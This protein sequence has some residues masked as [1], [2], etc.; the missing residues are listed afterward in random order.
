MGCEGGLNGE[1]ACSVMKQVRRG[2]KRP[3]QSVVFLRTLRLNFIIV[4]GISICLLLLSTQMRIAIQKS[5]QDLC[6]SNLE[7]GLTQLNAQLDTVSNDI[8]NFRE[9]IMQNSPGGLHRYD[10]VNLLKAQ[11]TL[12]SILRG[13]PLLGE[14]AYVCENIDQVVTT[15]G[16]FYSIDDFNAAYN[17]E[18][19]D[20]NL[21]YSYLGENERLATIRF[22]PCTYVDS[23]YA[24]P[25][26]DAA[27][28]CAIPLDTERY[29]T[30]KGVAYT[31]LRQDELVS[32]AVSSRI[33]P[34]ASF[35]LYDNRAGRGDVCLMSYGEEIED[36]FE[37]VLVSSTGTLRAVIRVS[38]AYINAQMRDVNR[39]IAFLMIAAVLVGVGTAY[40]TAHRQYIPMRRVIGSLRE[41]NLLISPDR[42]EY[43]E[44]LSS[45]DTLITEKEIV[46]RRLSDYQESL[47]RN[48]LDRLFSNTL[49]KQDVEVM[50]RLQMK[51]FPK[52]FA[53][54]CG[55][56]FVGSADSNDSM[57]MTLVMLLD[58]L[59]KNLPANAILHSTD[60]ATFGLVYP[61]ENGLDAAEEALQRTLNAASE[62]FS[63]HVLLIRG[64]VC[65]SM[66]QIGACF[67]K[68]QMSY[69]EDYGQYLTDGVSIVPVQ[70]RAESDGRW[71]LRRLQALY[72]MMAAGNADRA[73]EEMREIYLSSGDDMP[74]DMRERYTML[75]A[76]I[77]MACPEIQEDMACPEIPSFQ[78]AM[79]QREQLEA[80]ERAVREVC[81]HVVDW[82]TDAMDERVNVYADY[83]EA[84][85]DDPELC[86]SSLAN[87][88][89]VSEKY[90]FTLFKKKTGYSPT[91]YLHHIRMEK[92]AQLLRETDDTVQNISARVGFANFGTFYKAFKREFGVAPGKFRAG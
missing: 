56:L 35:K 9:L 52:R 89:H 46:T 68:A 51:D 13:N 15:Q 69:I 57:Q 32:V 71:R 40:W 29:T 87:E 72:Q 36:G 24:A 74:I 41:R 23:R 49:L 54:Y 73:V 58:Y 28:C 77:L 42:D 18:G 8:I 45:V 31:F 88:F 90:L 14:I 65:E 44:L 43:D 84:H 26:F 80:L 92:A 47:Q 79:P 21:F 83:M 55:R 22:Y 10:A 1:G 11:T 66:S 85:F 19:M 30:S 48:I 20:T 12:K 53:V 38:N 78:P 37:T 64:G 70:E 67:E 60:T 34:Y 3:K 91:S 2:E 7:Y 82:Q 81:A 61:C 62:R 76:Y 25:P 16:V 5:E 6:R 4:A 39:F 17:I 27:F 86:A 63:A 50:L 33:R 59:K 75:R